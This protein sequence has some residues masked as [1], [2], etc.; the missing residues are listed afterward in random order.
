MPLGR[1]R[2]RS[3]SV[4]FTRA[5]KTAR[6]TG[7]MGTVSR[8]RRARSY[9]KL[10]PIAKKVNNLYK[11]IENKHFTWRTSSM[12][13]VPHNRSTVLQLQSGGPLN[14][15]RSVNGTDDP[16]G[17][18]G[19]RIGDMI[20]VTGLLIRGM[21]QNQFSRP[22]VFYRIMLVKCAKG[23]TIDDSTLFSGITTNRLID[24]MNTERFTIL[25]E[26]HFSVSTANVAQTG[27]N[28]AGE[29]Q[30]TGGGGQGTRLFKM[31]I[32]GSKFGPDGRVHFEN[33]S[34]GQVKFYDYRVVVVT[35][36]WNHS[37]TVTATNIGAINECYT[38]LYFKDA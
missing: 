30:G 25:A 9:Y 38:K 5:V 24:Q 28:A 16:M 11:L 6:K 35:Y 12:V 4:D 7:N 3:R 14:P 33:N 2:A 13:D 20:K 23:D 15:F 21:V 1:K 36:D 18:G 27:T 8:A 29:P 34:Q 10:R 17:T 31:W 37:P 26:T 32:P 19:S 22:K